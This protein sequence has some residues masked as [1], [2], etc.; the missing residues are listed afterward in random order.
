VVISTA[1]ARS[2]GNPI[3]SPPPLPRRKS[4][5]AAHAECYESTASGD[6]EHLII[7]SL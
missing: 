2:D 3:A 4:A 5:A 1:P 6:D 7:F